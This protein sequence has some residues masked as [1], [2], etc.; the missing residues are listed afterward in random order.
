[1]TDQPPEPPKH[2]VSDPRPAQRAIKRTE[3]LARRRKVSQ[4]HLSRI[5]QKEIAKR[6]EVSE[7]CV[8]N[9]LKKVHEAWK[10][11]YTHDAQRLKWRETAAL[12]SDEARIRARLASVPDVPLLQAQA[13]AEDRALHAELWD[14]VS[15][16]YCRLQET[17]IKIMTLRAKLLGLEAP[18]K[19]EHTGEQALRVEFVNDW[20]PVPSVEI[21]E[22][23]PQNGNG[24]G[25]GH[26]EPLE[27]TPPAG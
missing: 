17:A 12:D 5:P 8:S 21:T 24:N 19:V 13:G 27:A 4:L 16:T 26:A 22:V 1:M 11:E 6:L 9:D 20:Q 3:I 14:S 23:A 7:A 15:R 18:Q 25:N 10:T 2:P